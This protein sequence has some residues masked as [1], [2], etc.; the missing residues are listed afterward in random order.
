MPKIPKLTNVTI[1]LEGNVAD[2][3]LSRPDKL[4][5]L[6]LGLMEDII[7]AAKWASENSEVRRVVLSGEGRG[8]CAGIDMEGLK[9]NADGKFTDLVKRT[10]GNTNFFQ[11]VAWGWRE[12]RVPV[13]AAL[14]GVAIGGGFQVA[15]GA[16]IRI[17]HP[18][19]KMSIMEMKWGFM[20]RM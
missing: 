5:A 10:H 18:K 3:R 9:S 17:V 15:L 13:I 2:I 11:Q 12:C 6:S 8:F 20:F 19:S 7:S 4:N 14:H 16:D 1:V